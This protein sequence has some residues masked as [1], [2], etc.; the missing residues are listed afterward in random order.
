MTS[1]VHLV[2][3]QRLLRCVCDSCKE[4]HQATAEDLAFLGPAG[5]QMSEVK[6]FKGRGC[7]RC[8]LTGYSGRKGIFELMEMSSE[9]RDMSF[10]K[11]PTMEMRAKARSEGMVTLQED[12]RP[13]RGWVHEKHLSR[14]A[15]PGETTGTEAAREPLLPA[16][17]PPR[18]PDAA[19]DVPAAGNEPRR[20]PD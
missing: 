6:L 8:A 15:S 1:A 7:S 13:I 20:V 11:R 12:G 9:L 2:M 17:I 14:V 18:R 10:H 3:A 19:G 4:E 16:R 5:K